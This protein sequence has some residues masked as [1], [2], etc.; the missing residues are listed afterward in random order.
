MRD[1]HKPERGH[2]VPDD[3]QRAQLEAA[4]HPA[5]ADYARQEGA[6]VVTYW[7]APLRRGQGTQPRLYLDLSACVTTWRRADGEGER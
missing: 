7:G 1:P 5:S 6:Y 3:E 4:G 2:V